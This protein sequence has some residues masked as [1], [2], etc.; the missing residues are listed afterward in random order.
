M[1]GIFVPYFV[2][3]TYVA[4]NQANYLGTV[5]TFAPAGSGIP[6]AKAQYWVAD[7]PVPATSCPSTAGSCGGAG[8]GGIYDDIACANPAPLACGAGLQLTIDPNSGT[9]PTN[10][11]QV[12]PAAQCLIHATGPGIGNGQDI[13]A[14]AGIGTPVAITPGDN[15]PNPAFRGQAGMNISRSDSIITVPI[16]NWVSNPCPGVP[17]NTSAATVNIVGYLQLGI[18]AVDATGNIQA[19]IMNVASCNPGAG[20]NPVLGGGVAPVPVRLIHN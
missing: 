13:F 16:F 2:D 7:M 17:C 10:T 6:L 18:Q 5:F 12:S 4:A 8:G 11:T 15:N 20:S 19:V 14:P 3:A 9:I 1:G